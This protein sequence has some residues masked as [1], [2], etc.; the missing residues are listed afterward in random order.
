MRFVIF[1]L[2]LFT[3]YVRSVFLNNCNVIVQHKTALEMREIVKQKCIK[4]SKH[5]EMTSDDE[6]FKFI[7]SIKSFSNF[8]GAI[9]NDVGCGPLV[10]LLATP[11][12]LEMVEKQK[13]LK[14]CQIDATLRNSITLNPRPFARS[15]C[16]KT[17]GFQ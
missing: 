7:N 6:I 9:I 3:S 4:Y 14:K 8:V 16:E 15:N 1:I 13:A 2:A 12:K 10:D 5:M 17:A 11:T